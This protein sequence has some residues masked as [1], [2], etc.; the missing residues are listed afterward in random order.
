MDILLDPKEGQ[1]EEVKEQAATGEVNNAEQE[2]K[3]EEKVEG[4]EALVD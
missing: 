4:D 3:E 1:Q 2:I